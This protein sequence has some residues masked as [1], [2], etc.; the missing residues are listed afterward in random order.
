MVQQ[1]QESCASR[2]MV[3]LEMINDRRPKRRTFEAKRQSILSSSKGTNWIA[4]HGRS[5]N[6]SQSTL[7]SRSPKL[8]RSMPHIT[9]QTDWDAPFFSRI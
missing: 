9:L 6:Q 3:V 7:L 5:I 1:V 2:S 8:R 4:F